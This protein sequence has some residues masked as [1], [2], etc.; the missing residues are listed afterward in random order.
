VLQTSREVRPFWALQPLFTFTFTFTFHHTLHS[1]DTLVCSNHDMLVKL[2]LVPGG[3][4]C[5]KRHS[6]PQDGDFNKN[7]GQPQH[8][9]QRA[10][11]GASREG[12]RGP[13][14]VHGRAADHW[15]CAEGGREWLGSARRRT[16]DATQ[17]FF[18]ATFGKPRLEFICNHEQ[19]SVS[20]GTAAF[21]CA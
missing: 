4:S 13:A 8:G 17:L 18:T 20:T 19:V 9:L 7:E 16:A 2:F 14:L 10:R 5:L 21:S 12:D 15:H 3:Q 11:P 1:P 6:Q